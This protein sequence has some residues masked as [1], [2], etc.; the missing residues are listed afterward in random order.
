VDW[1]LTPANA[2]A[3]LSALRGKVDAPRFTNGKPARI[4][5]PL[6]DLRRTPE[7]PRERQLLLGDAVTVIDRHKGWAFLQAAKD[8][9][10]GYVPSRALKPAIP[11]THWVAAPSTHLYDEPRVQARDRASLSMGSQ[12]TVTATGAHFAETG[13]GFVPTVHLRLLG[14]W[15]HD[16]VYVAEL[17]LGTPYLW[18]GN[19]R[20]GLDCSGLV[21]TAF[22]A[23]GRGCPADSDL[24]QSIGQPLAE[25]APLQRGDLLFWK[26]H[27]AMVVD[28]TRLIH[29]NGHSMS[30]AHEDIESCVARIL[31]QGGGP[32]TA[33]RRP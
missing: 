22:L 19:S 26:G 21:Q 30:V 24:Q 10:C 4:G 28:G 13:F 32:V 12:V 29:A 15:F 7:G 11:A 31:A 9:Y 14:D 6:V 16:P 33:R 2:H 3:A 27:V 18:G 8:G 17:F 23:C 25:F 5:V 1:R 20:A